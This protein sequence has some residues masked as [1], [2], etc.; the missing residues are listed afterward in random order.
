M[1]D[2]IRRPYRAEHAAALTDLLNTIEVHGGGHAGYLAAEVNAEIA[3]LVPDLATDTTLVFG[4]ELI[5]AAVT[6]APPVGGYRMSLWGGV[7][8]A[9]R[10]QGLGRELLAAQLA[11]AEEI[12]RTV[13]PGGNWEA[14]AGT[15]IGD[16]DTLRLF[17]RLNLAPARYWF[18]MVASTAEPVSLDLPDR[19]RAAPYQPSDENATYDAH[20]EAFRDHWGYQQRT[21]PDWVD[22]TVGSEIFLP[23]MSRLAYDGEDLAGYVLSYQ[24]GDPTE[25]YIGQVGTRRPWRRTG[26]A[27]GLLSQII[28]AAR[29]AGYATVALGVDADS[30]TGAVGAYTR[31]G[32]KV[33]SRAV[34]YSYALPAL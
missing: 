10:G 28:T 31:V 4:P 6:V 19:L 21:R 14:H 29:D 15:M 20:I 12:H 25:L 3:Q 1:A 18:E 11:R 27:G 5:A 32:F 30:P 13:A 24:E 23:A 16:E 7:H 34:T 17:E 26:V 8:P 33:R 22:L 2:L 9:W